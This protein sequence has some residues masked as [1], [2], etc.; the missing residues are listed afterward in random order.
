MRGS[1]N[2]E[3]VKSDETSFFIQNKFDLV[4][5]A[6]GHK[7]AASIQARLRWRT[8]LESSI[9]ASKS[10]LAIAAMPRFRNQ[11]AWLLIEPGVA[12]V[13]LARAATNYFDQV[14]ILCT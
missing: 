8:T 1:E 11:A 10:G 7:L 9:V 13:V 4:R 14:S 12:E 2:N 3:T 5:T 6:G